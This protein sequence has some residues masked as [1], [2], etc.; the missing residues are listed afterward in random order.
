MSTVTQDWKRPPVIEVVLGVQFD[1]L[2]DLTNGHLGWF[3]GEMHREFPNSD[4]V[5]PIPPVREP[6][7][8]ESLFGF[9]AL[10]VRP[11][12]G[13]SRLRM[14]SSD[15]TKMIQVQN[16]WLVANWTRKGDSD[17]PGFRGVK[18][19]FDDGLRRFSTFLKQRNLGVIR[20]NLWEVTYIDHIPIGTVWHIPADLPR[21]FPGLFGEARCASGANESVDATWRWRLSPMPGRLRVS[22]QSA[23]TS[24]EPVRDILLVRSIARGPL[25]PDNADSLDDA[26]N[27]G[28]SAVVDTFMG[29]A[30]DDA[31]Q[32]WMGG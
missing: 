16:G 31:K 18:T 28:R 4:D 30:S 11:V 3:W 9:P 21:V 25:G 6:F 32:Y 1:R 24:L 12:S 5:P 27:F 26:L 22:V 14:T 13:E 10:D 17:Y 20:P 7:D 29:L 15:G 8:D 2:P 23:R 19:L